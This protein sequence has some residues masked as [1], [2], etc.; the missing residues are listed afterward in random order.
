MRAGS[1][2]AWGLA[3]M[4][5]VIALAQTAC[6]D[7]EFRFSARS[8]PLAHIDAPYEFRLRTL[9]NDADASIRLSRDSLLPQGLRVVIGKR[10]IRFVG[11]PTEAGSFPVTVEAVV[12]G[13]LAISRDYTLRVSDELY[14]HTE[15]LPQGAFDI[16]YLQDI[17]ATG[18]SGAGYQWSI[19]SG[20]LP[21]GLGV[22]SGT[23]DGTIFGTPVFEGMYS[24]TLMVTDS[25]SNV[26]TRDFSIFIGAKLS[27]TFPFPAIEPV[28]AQAYSMQFMVSGGSGGYVWY[29]ENG[30]LP[31]GLT[32]TKTGA[33][34]ARLS[35]TPTAA[36]NYMFEVRA[37]D[38]MGGIGL[39][40]FNWTVDDAL[41]IVDTTVPD[42]S[43]GVGYGYT[44]TASGGFGNPHTW[45][46]VSGVLPPGLTLQSASTGNPLGT[47]SGIPTAQGMYTFTVQVV[48]GGTGVDTQVFTMVIN[49]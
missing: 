13:G 31:P 18:G 39:A 4:L 2:S 6:D 47:I 26:A 3:G 33:T 32:L 40:A 37:R 9:G 8:L 16:F 29:I 17:L 21:P 14:I 24:F 49:P 30:E 34:T 48:D 1:W 43:V 44:L 10:S 41:T 35:G 11:T 7:S 23:P 45:S 46:V 25:A 5:V 28:V 19:S 20:A 36:G 38:S 27:V 42:G 15:T 22:T 12:P